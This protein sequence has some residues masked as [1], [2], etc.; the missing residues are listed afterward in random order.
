MLTTRWAFDGLFPFGFLILCS[1]L[2]PAD[3]LERADRFFA[4]MRTPV[5]PTPEL[6]KREVEL[7]Y[8]MPHRFD[9]K[10]IFANS[11][12]QFTRW[13]ANDL[14]GFAGCWLIVATILVV[15]WAVLHI[16]S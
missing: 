16:G 7:S 11:N 4:K 13:S 2:S 1:F 8:Q 10:K 15:L 5:A 6:D 14:L 12:W 9:Q 3:E